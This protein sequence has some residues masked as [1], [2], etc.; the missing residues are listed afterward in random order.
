[1]TGWATCHVCPCP[2]PRATSERGAS[3][4]SRG[5][6]PPHRGQRKLI[7]TGSAFGLIRTVLRG[8]IRRFVRTIPE[9]LPAWGDAGGRPGYSLGVMEAPA[10]WTIYPKADRDEVEDLVTR[11]AA[12]L[13]IDKP[14]LQDT[15]VAL[16]PMVPAS[17]RHS[18]GSNPAGVKGGCCSRQARTSRRFVQVSHASRLPS[19]RRARSRPRRLRRGAPP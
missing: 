16:R 3:Q 14:P 18:T 11:L 5:W 17:A 1:M 9:S 8:G 4:R 7:W 10:M 2:S 15:T 12:E 6:G 13:G 19:N